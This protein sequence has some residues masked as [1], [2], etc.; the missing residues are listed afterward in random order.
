MI[1]LFLR[2]EILSDEEAQEVTRLLNK[3][4]VKNNKWQ[5]D[6]SS[7]FLQDSITSSMYESSGAVSLNDSMG[8]PSLQDE[9]TT[10]E[11]TEHLSDYIINRTFDVTEPKQKGAADS[12]RS[13]IYDSTSSID[14]SA[15]EDGFT[16]SKGDA[17]VSDSCLLG[18]LR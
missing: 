4:G 11:S 3:D 2:A 10:A 14:T 8:P 6:A 5:P 7:S 18:K 17:S 1:S 9:S 12:S 15:H 13:Q 16:Q